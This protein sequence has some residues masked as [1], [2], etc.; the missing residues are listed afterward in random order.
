MK[1]F[2]SILVKGLFGMH[3]WIPL[4]YSV[5]FLVITIMT[6]T[7]GASWSFYFLGLSVSLIA[8]LALCYYVC[9]HKKVR[10]EQPPEKKESA[11]VS[12]NERLEYQASDGFRDY[13]RIEEEA[14]RISEEQARYTKAMTGSPNIITPSSNFTEYMRATPPQPERGM[15]QAEAASRLYSETQNNDYIGKQKDKI[16]AHD[17]LY[18]SFS[19]SDNK[20]QTFSSYVQPNNSSTPGISLDE[21]YSR[22]QSEKHRTE[23]PTIYRTRKDPK[24]LVYEYSDRYE[25]YYV[26]DDGKL[27]LLSREFK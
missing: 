10:T 22:Q 9:T 8:S 4:T 25:R 23:K 12:K 15:G 21:Y 17:A 6:G 19:D 26:G 2:L 18:S 11:E 5:L 16:N 14:T 7:I 20:E 3:L 27:S 1:K 13:Q 24:V